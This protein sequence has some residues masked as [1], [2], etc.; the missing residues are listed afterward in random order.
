MTLPA[1]SRMVIFSRSFVLT[2]APRRGEGSREVGF[3]DPV[4]GGDPRGGAVSSPLW[5]RV[6][7]EVGRLQA[8][9]GGG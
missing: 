6:N 5:R 2:G 3:Q 9:G 8:L 4:G 7:R 1:T